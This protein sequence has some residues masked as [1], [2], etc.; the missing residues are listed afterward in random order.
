[1]LIVGQNSDKISKLKKKIS[2]FFAMNDL[3]PTKRILG[4]SIFHDRKTRKIWLSQETYI[5]KVLKWFVDKAKQVA[6]PFPSHFM[7]SSK[8][9]PT[10]EKEKEDMAMVPYSSGVGN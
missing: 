1:M 5:E 4:I 9:S 2:K 7:L 3:G 10:C 8:Q 6:T